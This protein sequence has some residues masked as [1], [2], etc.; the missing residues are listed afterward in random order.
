MSVRRVAV[1]SGSNKGIG[2]AIVKLLCDPTN[3]FSGDVILTARDETRGQNAVKQLNDLGLKPLFH[4][5]DID[6]NNSIDRLKQYLVDN[7][8]G[9]DVI[10]NN[11][12]IAY[13]YNSTVP[14]VEQAENTIKTNFF[15]TRNVCLK[16]FPILKSHA[17]VVNVSS[18]AGMLKNMPSIGNLLYI[19]FIIDFIALENVLIF[20]NYV[21]V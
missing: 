5:L 1:V 11:A 8:N 2:F 6:D 7:Y 13:S 10:V 20:L 9:V 19:S 17:R 21:F 3:G 12:A 14:F 18:S 4:Q 16:L 15:S